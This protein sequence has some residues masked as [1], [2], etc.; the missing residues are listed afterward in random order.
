MKRESPLIIIWLDNLGAFHRFMGELKNIADAFA[1]GVLSL[2]KGGTT[3]KNLISVVPSVTETVELTVKAGCSLE[4]MPVVGEVTFDRETQAMLHLKETARFDDLVGPDLARRLFTSFGFRTCQMGWK[5][6]GLGPVLSSPGQCAPN[7]LSI[8]SE[9][10]VRL[11]LKASYE[12]IPFR[13]TSFINALREHEADVYLLNI[14]G[15]SIVHNEAKAGQRRFMQRLDEEFPRLMASIRAYTLDPTIIMFSDHG[16]KPIEKHVKPEDFLKDVEGLI[17]HG[18]NRNAAVVS[19]GRGPL[20]V[21]V[22]NPGD[23]GL[24]RK[25]TYRELRNYRG[26]DILGAIAAKED[27]AFVASNLEEGGI[28]ILSRD[29]QAVLSER[30]GGFLY[31][32]VAGAD[33]LGLGQVEGRVVSAREMLAKTYDKEFPYPIQLLKLLQSPRCG[34]I[35]VAL[36]RKYAFFW[37]MP[38]VKTTHGGPSRSEITVSL[39]A[40]GPEDEEAGISYGR[41]LEYG[42]LA[43][44]YNSL[45]RIL[46]RGKSPHRGVGGDLLFGG[47]R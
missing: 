13:I 19:N 30:E 32:V 45:C 2:S 18:E 6:G 4:E 29:G 41:E 42:S 28:S 20:F 10:A 40:T 22:K 39:L 11:E 31:E 1:G 47:E 44:L 16:P 17:F 46:Y 5:L 21:Y 43:E 34:D 15:D 35:F 33:P 23:E 27:V 26:E 36:R 37:D 24:W 25:T 38:W 12:I 8:E 3:V 9:E 14:S 7:V